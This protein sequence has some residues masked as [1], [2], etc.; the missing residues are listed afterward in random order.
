MSDF[1]RQAAE[2]NSTFNRIL[3]LYEKLIVCVVNHENVKHKFNDILLSVAG[4]LVRTQCG[5]I[6]A[7]TLYGS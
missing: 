1:E 2:K 3:L 4:R 7:F 5:E 6:F